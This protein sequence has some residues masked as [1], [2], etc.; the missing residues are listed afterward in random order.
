M[1]RAETCGRKRGTVGRPCHN[2]VTRHGQVLWHGLPTMPRVR[3]KVC[4]ARS[5]DSSSWW[6]VAELV[7]H[8]EEVCWP[9]RRDCGELE[10]LGAGDLWSN[11]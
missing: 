5:S 7:V 4:W 11:A 9:C 3:P 6:C 2:V 8:G 1:A 10:T